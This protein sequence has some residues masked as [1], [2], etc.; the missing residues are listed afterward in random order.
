MNRVLAWLGE[1]AKMLLAKKKK[2]DLFCR[3]IHACACNLRAREHVANGEFVGSRYLRGRVKARLSKVG[4]VRAGQCDS[5]PQTNVWAPYRPLAD[6][7]FSVFMTGDLNSGHSGKLAL[8]PLSTSSAAPASCKIDTGDTVNVFT[9]DVL[10][11]LIPDTNT[12]SI[13]RFFSSDAAFL[14]L[15]FLFWGT[16]RA[17]SF[18]KIE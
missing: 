4:R 11:V 17:I 6:N 18:E 8:V 9:F 12:I 15:F 1:R 7:L 14:F 10:V 13:R 16:V 3:S 2:R 5:E